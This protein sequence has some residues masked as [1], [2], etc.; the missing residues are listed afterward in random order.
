M[1]KND[2]AVIS[3][4]NMMQG[5]I[6][7]MA[8]NSASCKQWCIALVS[9][10]LA[11]SKTKGFDTD[12]AECCKIPV[13]LF[14]FMDC[15]Y[16]GLEHQMKNKLDN[17]VIRLNK[18]KNVDADL[19]ST[20]SIQNSANGLCKSILGWTKHLL[21]QIAHTILAFFSLSIFPFY[22]CLYLLIEYLG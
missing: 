12:L 15:F 10:L 22:I 13:F 17:F 2:P 7:R 20:K 5:I 1:T 14:C 11:L 9:A 19:F 3:H 8:G 21:E 6:S 4:V 16:L 18:N